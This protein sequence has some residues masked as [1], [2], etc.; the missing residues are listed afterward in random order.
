LNHI[1]E[2]E[3][4][5]TEPAS[6]APPSREDLL[7]RRIGAALIDVALLSALLAILAAT[8]G[9]S[10]VG[11]GASYSFDLYGVEAAVYYALVLLYYFAL[12]VT[13]G[14]TVG[15]LLVGLRVV[16]TDGGRPSVAAIAVRTLV[17]VVDWLPFFYLVGFIAMLVPGERRQRLGDLAAR[18]GV[19]RALPVRHRS[20]AAAAVALVVL[21]LLGVSFYQAT[22]DD[23]VSDRR[24]NRRRLRRRLRLEKAKFSFR[25][26]SL[27]RPPAGA[28]LYMRRVKPATSRVPIA[29][30]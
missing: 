23:D 24:P 1:P 5:S 22:G 29:S 12:E 16:R 4:E 19:A 21:V 9:E 2:P 20:L 7:G 30:S 27:T 17:R 10:T 26:T 3:A 8:I 14:Q 18:T 11:D 6:T 13:L 28:P 25:T 15:K